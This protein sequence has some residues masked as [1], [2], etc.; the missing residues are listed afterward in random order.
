MNVGR[1]A[2][3]KEPDDL[4]ETCAVYQIYSGADCPHA[5]LQVEII[6]LRYERPSVETAGGITHKS[7]A[8]SVG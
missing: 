8:Q 5:P 1:K 7:D 3:K 6:L 4:P 2:F